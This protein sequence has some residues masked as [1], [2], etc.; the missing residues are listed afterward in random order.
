[1][2]NYKKV[3]L[4]KVIRDTFSEEVTMLGGKKKKN[5]KRSLTYRKVS[6]YVCVDVYMYV[7]VGSA[8][9]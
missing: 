4:Y 9:R 7:S 2:K 8:F 3:F 5:R 1:M 6:M